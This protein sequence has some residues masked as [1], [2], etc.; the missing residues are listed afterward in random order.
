MHFLQVSTC[1]FHHLTDRCVELQAHVWQH[2]HLLW[3][4]SQ[5][6]MLCSHRWGNKPVCQIRKCSQLS[7][8]CLVE[9]EK[10]KKKEKKKHTLSGIATKMVLEECQSLGHNLKMTSPSSLNLLKPPQSSSWLFVAMVHA[11][12]FYISIIK[13]TLTWTMWSLNAHKCYC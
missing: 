9:L 6:P 13:R 12:Y 10:G 5:S 8:M 11:G 2:G 1:L 7:N 4:V 3:T